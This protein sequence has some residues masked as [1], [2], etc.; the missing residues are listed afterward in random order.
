MKPLFYLKKELVVFSIW[1]S[2]QVLQKARTK[3]V[4]G[5]IYT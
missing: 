4:A 5:A 1:K 2:L 3:I